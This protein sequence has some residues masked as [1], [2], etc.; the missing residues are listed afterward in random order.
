M[1]SIEFSASNTGVSISV[2]TWAAKPP[3]FKG[4]VIPSNTGRRPTCY[5][6]WQEWEHP[7]EGECIRRDSSVFFHRDELVA[8]QQR[9]NEMV[10]EFDACIA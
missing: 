4:C 6:Q 9:V 5:L 2:H 8:L 3:E 7:E 1:K 10:E